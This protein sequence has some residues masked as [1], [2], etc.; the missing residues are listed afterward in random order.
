MFHVEHFPPKASPKAE[1]CSDSAR[2]LGQ[3]RTDSGWL[4][5]T[6]MFHVEHFKLCRCS[7]WNI[8]RQRPSKGGQRR[9]PD[10][11]PQFPMENSA[12]LSK[13]PMFHV[14]HFSAKGLLRVETNSAED[15]DVPRG[16]F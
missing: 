4:S 15:P 3:F 13:T 8:F 10:K 16:T 5:K 11:A 2:K 6:P 1:R 12:G 9:Q 14:E 7:T